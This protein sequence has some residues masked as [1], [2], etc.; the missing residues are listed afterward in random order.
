MKTPIKDSWRGNVWICH[1][2]DNYV[3]GRKDR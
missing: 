2:E 3:H 1:A